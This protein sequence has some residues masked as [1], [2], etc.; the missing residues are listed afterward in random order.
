[1]I[2][3]NHQ[4]KFHEQVTAVVDAALQADNA[5]REKRRYLG[6]SRLGIACERALQFEY[7][8]APVDVGSEFPGRTLRIFDVGHALEDL[9]IRWLRL[10]GFDL[11]TRRQDGEQFG[12]SVADARIQGH[13]DGVIA[14]APPQLGLA[15]PML[16]ECKTMSDKHWRDTVKRGVT[17]TKPVYAAQLA[18]YQAYMAYSIPGISD[19]PALFTAINKDTQEL[20]FELVPF[21]RGLAQRMSDRAV[22]VLRATEA[23]E[24]LPRVAAEPGYYECKYCAWAKRCWA[25]CA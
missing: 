8:D 7:A 24:Q 4:L 23:G 11:Y 20:W 12:F 5:T 10:A 15:F 1:M 3:L 19:H 13:L 25:V 21:D 17:A 9:A 16:W 6:G 14:A 2:D 22:R 18:T